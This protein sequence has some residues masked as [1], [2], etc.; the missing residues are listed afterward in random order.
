MD[1]ELHLRV[2]AAQDEE[3]ASLREHH[4]GAAAGGLVAEVTADPVRLDIGMVDSRRFFV[5]QYDGSAGS[6]GDRLEAELSGFLD[7][8]AGDVREAGMC[9]NTPKNGKQS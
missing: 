4:C 9:L 3:V 8:D 7:D 6:Q 2:Y 5:G 1:G